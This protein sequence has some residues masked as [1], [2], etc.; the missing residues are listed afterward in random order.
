MSD[1][2]INYLPAKITGFNVTVDIVIP[3]GDILAIVKNNQCSRVS[4]DKLNAIRE[5]RAKYS[6]GLMDTRNMIEAIM[7]ELGIPRSLG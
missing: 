5:V 3:A 4:F 1:L 7:E 6:T 2:Q